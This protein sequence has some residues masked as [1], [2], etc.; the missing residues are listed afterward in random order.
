MFRTDLFTPYRYT[1]NGF[2]PSLGHLAVLSILLSAFSYLVYK[3]LPERE[4]LQK[5]RETGYLWLTILLLPGAFLFI[6]Y[7]IIFS[8]LIFN[9][10]INFE[11]FKVLELDLFSLA[12]LFF[13]ALLFCIPFLYIVK[14]FRIYK[15]ASAETF[16]VGIIDHNDCFCL[17][18]LSRL[19]NVHCRGVCF[20]P[21]SLQ[22]LAF[23]EEEILVFLIRPLYFQ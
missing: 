11:T 6:L 17:F 12:G 22:R 3:Y 5:S 10:N 4:N 16:P 14:I 18:L 2:I 23:W 19:P 20:I 15:A 8:H 7:H 13:L 1:M 21:L 9:S